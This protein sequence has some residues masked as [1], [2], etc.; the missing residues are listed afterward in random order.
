MK[1]Y[2]LLVHGIGIHDKDWANS[3]IQKLEKKTMSKLSELA[4]EIKVSGAQEIVEFRAFNWDNLFYQRQMILQGVLSVRS[5]PRII[6]NIQSFFNPLFFIANAASEW[7][8]KKVRPIQTKVISQ[9]ISDILA[10]RDQEAAALLHAHLENTLFDWKLDVSEEKAPFTVISH[11]LGT[12]IASGYIYDCNK[13]G[14]EF[15]KK[16]I[17]ENL[18]TIGS[19]IALFSLQYGDDPDVFSSPIRVETSEGRWLNIF[20]DDDPVGMP[21]KGLNK[22]YSEAVS[23]DIQ[24]DAGIF[25]VSHTGYFDNEAVL[26]LITHKLVIDW[27]RYNEKLPAD[28]VMSLLREYDRKLEPQK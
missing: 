16:F 21:L 24:V 13:F 5:K 19:P 22:A 15:D 27:L 25:G 8:T 26:D 12:V 28:K 9:F 1:L 17:F 4:S 14:H 10:Y 18:F 7:F 6:Q 20:D 2:A 11:S 3:L 23:Q